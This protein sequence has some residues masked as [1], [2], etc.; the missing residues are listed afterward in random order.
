MK[1]HI[2]ATVTGVLNGDNKAAANEL[3]YPNIKA[4]NLNESR[5][6]YV[7]LTPSSWKLPFQTANPG[8]IRVAGGVEMQFWSKLKS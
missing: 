3:T 1:N 7:S 5:Y 6:H 4:S 2:F 8:T